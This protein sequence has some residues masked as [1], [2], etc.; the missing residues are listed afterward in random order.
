MNE[1]LVSSDYLD[2]FRIALDKTHGIV[3][4]L[5]C[6]IGILPLSI[7]SHIKQ[8]GHF[9]ADAPKIGAELTRLSHGRELCQEALQLASFVP[10]TLNL[11]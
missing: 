7:V 1:T 9:N 10:G 4:C 5:Q 6:H 8:H 2:A 11:I 3:I